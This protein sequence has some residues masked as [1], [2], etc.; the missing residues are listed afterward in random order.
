MQLVESYRDEAGKRRQGTIATV[1]RVDETGGAVDSL[2]SGLLRATGR[3]AADAPG[4]PPELSPGS[5]GIRFDS[6]LAFGDVFALDRLRHELGCNE[7]AGLLRPARLIFDAEALVRAMVFNR[8]CDVCDATSKLGLLRWLQTTWLPGI[9]PVEV[10]HQRLLRPMAALQAQADAVASL[11]SRLLRPLIDQRLSVVFYDLTTLRAEGL[12]EQ[13]GD[14][15]RFGLAKEGI[16]ARQCLLSVVQ[17]AEG[18]PTQVRQV[19]VD[20]LDHRRRKVCGDAL[21]LA[22]AV[23]AVLQDA[24]P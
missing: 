15:R 6:S 24:R 11:V 2:L 23:R 8:L 13:P 9:D 12:S 18:L 22:R 19:L 10:T 17:T 1:G 16:I 20:L 3:P 4:D 7:I 5:A 21:Q 14:L